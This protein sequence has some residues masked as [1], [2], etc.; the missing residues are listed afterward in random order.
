MAKKLEGLHPPPR[1]QGETLRE[2]TDGTARRLCPQALERCRKGSA[3]TRPAQAE[4]AHSRRQGG[5]SL[6]SAD[7]N[8]LPDEASPA[9]LSVVWQPRERG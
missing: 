9:A 6:P 8:P 7:S 5:A 1:W 2:A 4:Q 3:G